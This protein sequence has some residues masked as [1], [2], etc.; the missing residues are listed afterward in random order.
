MTRDKGVLFYDGRQALR[1]VRFAGAPEGTPLQQD[2]QIASSL[3][4]TPSARSFGSPSQRQGTVLFFI[5]SSALF[6]QYFISSGGHGKCRN[7]VLV[8]AY[9]FDFSDCC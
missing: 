3:T 6:D 5:S 9:T 7:H 2:G 8:K 1:P 4:A